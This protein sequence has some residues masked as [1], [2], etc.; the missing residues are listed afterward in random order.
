[1]KQSKDIERLVSILAS[2][3]KSQRSDAA[4][5][6]YWIFRCGED[7][8]I[9][10]RKAMEYL[11]AAADNGSV[12]AFYY[13]GWHYESGTFVRKD[14]LKSRFSRLSSY[15]GETS[16]GRREGAAGRLPV[17]ITARPGPGHPAP[18]EV[19]GDPADRPADRQPAAAPGTS[20]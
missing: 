7:V 9:D 14:I 19:P 13:L 5:Q 16:G 10:K 18:A 15:L 3:S 2:G 17:W 6:L 8:K 12:G 11:R 1:M 20:C 4:Y